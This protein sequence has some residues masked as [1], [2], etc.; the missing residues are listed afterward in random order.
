M[1]S[2]ELKVI[3]LGTEYQRQYPVEI[4][5]LKYLIGSD[6]EKQKQNNE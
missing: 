4:D 5:K 2:L 3:F 1:K 6:L